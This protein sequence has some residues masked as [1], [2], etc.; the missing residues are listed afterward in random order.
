M[1]ITLFTNREDRQPDSRQ[2]STNHG[3]TFNFAHV[4]FNSRI[5]SDTARLH[6]AITRRI[7]KLYTQ[8]IF[9]LPEQFLKTLAIQADSV[10]ILLNSLDY[11][12][13]NAK[14]IGLPRIP[15]IVDSLSYHYDAVSRFTSWVRQGPP[16]KSELEIRTQ[17]N[18]LVHN[19]TAINRVA[20]EYR[21][22]ERHLRLGHDAIMAD[23]NAMKEKRTPPPSVRMARDQRPVVN[24]VRPGDLALLLPDA[25]T[26]TVAAL[27]EY[28]RPVRVRNMILEAKYADYPDKLDVEECEKV[29]L[30]MMKWDHYNHGNYQSQ[31]Q[32]IFNSPP[33][34][35]T[36]R[37][38]RNGG[39]NVG[40]MLPPPPGLY[41]RR[42]SEERIIAGQG[43]IIKADYQPKS[44]ASMTSEDIESESKPQEE[45][46]MV[47]K[48]EEKV[49]ENEIK[50]KEKKKRKKNKGKK[51]GK[52]NKGNKGEGKEDS[53][54]PVAAEELSRE[55]NETDAE[56][57]DAK[58]HL[59][60]DSSP[61]VKKL[62]PFSIIS[63][64]GLDSD[65]ESESQPETTSVTR[66]YP[67]EN[68]FLEDLDTS[69]PETELG[70]RT[71]EMDHAFID[72][73]IIGHEAEESIEEGIGL[74]N[75]KL[76]GE[77]VFEDCYE[78]S[79]LS[80]SSVERVDRF[81]PSEWMQ[82]DPK[83]ELTAVLPDDD[84]IGGESLKGGGFQGEK[85]SG[86][87]NELKDNLHDRKVPSPEAAISGDL[88]VHGDKSLDPKTEDE[89]SI[90]FVPLLKDISFS[91]LGVME[92]SIQSKD[93]NELDH[94]MAKAM[95]PL[96]NSHST[97]IPYIELPEKEGKPNTY[98][99]GGPTENRCNAG[100]KIDSPGSILDVAQASDIDEDPE[101]HNADNP[102][103]HE[104]VLPLD[105]LIEKSS[106]QKSE[107]G[108]RYASANTPQ[109]ADAPSPGKHNVAENCEDCITTAE[110]AD[111]DWKV[112]KEEHTLTDA[113][114]EAWNRAYIEN[115]TVN[116]EIEHTNDFLDKV[117]EHSHDNRTADF[118]AEEGLSKKE[119]S[120][121]TD[122]P[123]LQ[124]TDEL[125]RCCGGSGIVQVGGGCNKDTPPQ[126]VEGKRTQVR[127]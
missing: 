127:N 32:R 15:E 99:P 94:D 56:Y 93:G 49:P 14:W 110:A 24:N 126:A 39:R 108:H 60:V 80:S 95:E 36:P 118:A 40:A 85:Q 27:L 79:Y 104:D 83:K 102:D 25:P 82:S 92:T 100:E 54:Q 11:Y 87:C 123:G 73:P 74:L 90:R 109:E 43:S 22:V 65:A 50:E 16:P 98:K 55:A 96:D 51:K 116:E 117:V 26:P 112:D 111:L 103:G 71:T 101:D 35:G 28:E 107:S 44:N 34:Y 41:R 89:Y 9:E 8:P 31:G 77:D 2:I 125:C 120:T 62:R 53:I 63:L 33:G 113:E 66:Y 122:R 21:M 17:L 121:T 61:D 3:P 6:F 78:K 29:E 45:E 10:L 37:K 13:D 4:T 48:P 72:M 52:K 75:Y 19:L 64:E 12:G 91:A 67:D 106:G 68:L 59:D 18:V 57:Y 124:K 46:E 88:D 69:D 20:C 23:W 38:S 42:R 7:D 30:L 1:L 58:S 114:V 86:S 105:K 97:V 47:N 76:S 70:D 119:D 5:F 81:E 84:N 115:S